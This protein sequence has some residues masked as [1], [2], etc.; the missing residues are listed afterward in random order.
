MKILRLK[1]FAGMSSKFILDLIIFSSLAGFLYVTARVLPRINQVENDDSLKTS[2]LVNYI[3]K[4]D[5]KL[6]VTAEKTFRKLRVS[7]LKIDNYLTQ[8]INGFKK[9]GGKLNDT[10]GRFL[11]GSESQAQDEEKKPE[12]EEE[13]KNVL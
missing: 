4:A 3:E 8:R 9:E 2:K 6:K 13:S 10:N 12:A 7:I 5:E 1:D 11:A